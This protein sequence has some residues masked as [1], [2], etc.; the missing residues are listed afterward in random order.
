LATARW[1]LSHQLLDMQNVEVSLAG[2]FDC[3]QDVEDLLLKYLGTIPRRT[4]FS[5]LPGAAELS[6]VPP[7]VNPFSAH[8]ALPATSG[9][10]ENFVLSLIKKEFPSKINFT[11]EARVKWQHLSEDEERRAIVYLC[12]P[13]MNRWGYTKFTAPPSDTLVNGETAMDTENASPASAVQQRVKQHPLWKSRVANLM[14][15]VR[16]TDVSIALQRLL[17]TWLFS[18]R[19]Y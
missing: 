6:I 1:L 16:A 2:H 10:S 14:V 18:V 12:F 5:P 9:E 19:R 15:E 11:D 3:L 13:V 7:P 17:L 4:S 8:L